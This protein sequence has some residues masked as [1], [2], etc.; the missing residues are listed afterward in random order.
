[1]PYK[2]QIIKKAKQKTSNWSGG[3]TT[4]L[5]IYP[6]DASYAK[7]NFKWRLSSAIVNAEESS[8]TSLPGFWRLIMIIDGEILLKHEGHHDI[9][10]KPFEQ[11]SFSGDWTTKSY[12]R[13]RDFNLMIAEG[14]SGE[15]KT[16]EL[17]L[18]KEY[19]DSIELND[20][21]H[22][23]VTRF[24]Y[25]VK[26]NISFYINDKISEDLYEGDLLLINN[27]KQSCE[28]TIRLSALENKNAYIICGSISNS[29]L[30]V[31][32]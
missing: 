10:L 30:K 23:E 1:M 22:A 28:E 20:C 24:F 9:Y 32:N 14:F 16:I 5:S 4:E 11:D 19:R 26:G 17:S 13:V 15:L 25:C 18:E 27:N 8:F 2:I 7:R 29:S 21:E 12:G 6:K 31:I 3:T